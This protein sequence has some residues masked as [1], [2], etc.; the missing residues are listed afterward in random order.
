VDR[1]RAGARVEVL[2]ADQDTAD[3]VAGPRGAALDVV[4]VDVEVDG[5]GCRLASAAAHGGRRGGLVL[6]KAVARLVRGG[7]ARPHPGR[8][9]E[10]GVV[11]LEWCVEVDRAV[12]GGHRDPVDA[13]IVARVGL[14]EARAVR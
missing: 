7:E 4:V 8:G 10:A 9:A 2:D 12:Y 14:V 13:Q 11:A 3:R 5:A 1:E 6:V